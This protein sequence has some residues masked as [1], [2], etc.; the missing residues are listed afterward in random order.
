MEW[1]LSKVIRIENGEDEDRRDVSLPDDRRSS[2]NTLGR[3]LRDGAML[4]HH[5]LPDSSM[6]LQV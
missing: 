1:S 6:Y 3:R 5:P 2:S 4:V